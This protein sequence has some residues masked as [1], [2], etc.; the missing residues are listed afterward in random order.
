MLQPAQ[1]VGI[2]SGQHTVW[3][4][5][6]RDRIKVLK[7]GPGHSDLLDQEPYPLEPHHFYL[8]SWHTE[9]ICFAMTKSASCVTGHFSH[10]IDYFELSAI[11]LYKRYHPVGAHRPTYALRKHLGVCTSSVLNLVLIRCS[12]AH[13]MFFLSLVGHDN[14]N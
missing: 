3:E 1:Q 9:C 11:F 8:V 4:K 5:E 14:P 6:T 13:T 7:M 2:E 12:K 10:F